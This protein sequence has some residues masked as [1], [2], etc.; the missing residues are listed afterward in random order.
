MFSGS[1]GSSS[2]LSGLYGLVGEYNNIRSGAYFKALKAYYAKDAK[3][4]SSSSS[5][6]TNKEDKTTEIKDN[7]STRSY[8]NVKSEAAELKKSA[9]ALTKT[10]TDSLFTE[11]ERRVKNETTGKYETVKDVDM[12]EIQEAVKNF[13][14]SYNDTMKAANKTGNADIIRNAGYMA[15]Q[16]KIHSR[17]LS[18]VGIS[19]NKD[20]TL[21]I[22]TEKL[23]SANLDN[24]KTLFNGKDSYANFVSK[25]AD[26][27]TNAATKAASSSGNFY[28]N[29]GNYSNYSYNTNSLDW[30][31]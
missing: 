20:N 13:V 22:D 9:E 10:G 26:M 19:I 16:S 5:N 14:N 28:N 12:G 11:K 15:T 6:S 18:E 2:G 7:A 24:L 27:V 25:R 23:E 4:S 8:A 21:S 29:N 17:A 31:L 3:S 1:G 30:Y